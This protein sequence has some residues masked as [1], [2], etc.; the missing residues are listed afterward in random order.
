MSGAVCVCVQPSVFWAT[1]GKAGGGGV[2]MSGAV[3]VKPSVL[4]G[5]LNDGAE[6]IWS[7]SRH[8]DRNWTLLCYVCVQCASIV[9][10]VSRSG[11]TLESLSLLFVGWL[12]A[13]RPSNILSAVVV[14]VVVTAVG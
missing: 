2:F 13:K 10:E 14:C 5:L 11:T 1:L 4:W 9:A 3:Y 8:L 6:W 12:V 7:L